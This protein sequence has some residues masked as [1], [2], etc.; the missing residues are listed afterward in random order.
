MMG[1][2]MTTIGRGGRHLLIDV[3]LLSLPAY[4]SAVLVAR[5]DAALSQWHFVILYIGCYVLW[6]AGMRHISAWLRE[7]YGV[8]YMVRFAVVGGC[9]L[10]ACAMLVGQTVFHAVMFA[11]PRRLWVVAKSLP[12][13]GWFVPLFILPLAAVVVAIGDLGL[14]RKGPTDSRGVSAAMLKALTIS[15][16]TALILRFFW[17]GTALRVANQLLK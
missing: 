12:T 11:S 14:G 6:A 8:S 7:D 15:F 2:A 13:I 5:A 9:M 1:G 4:V 17:E 10:P 16:A 3:T